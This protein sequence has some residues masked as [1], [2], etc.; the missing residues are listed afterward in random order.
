MPTSTASRDSVDVVI[1]G[2]GSAGCVLAERLSRHEKRSVLVLEQG[3]SEW[4][5]A[6]VLDL[7]RL[8]ISDGERY[9][10]HHR[11][12]S[13]LP[14]V[15]GRGLG[16]SSTVNGGYFM[17]FHRGDFDSWQRPWTPDVIDGAYAEVDEKMG[18][19]PFADADL[20][21]TA[22]AFEKYWGGTFP[23]RPLDDPW[24]LV[25][26]NRVRSN[27]MDGIRRTAADAYLRPHRDRPNLRVRTGATVERILL[28]EGNA[29]GVVCDGQDIRAREVILCAGTL[30]SAAVLLRS[31]V[32]GERMRV[33]EHREVLVGYRLREQLTPGPLLP[34]V[35]HTDDG[36]EIRC[37]RD[38]FARYIG[39]L[40]V[41]GP[42]VGVA[43]MTPGAS[44]E[45]YLDGG[46]VGVRLDQPDARVL[47]HL[48]RT[49][50]E[51]VEMLRSSSFGELVVADS[52][53]IDP[54]LRTSQH[55]WGSMPMG[56]RTDWLGGVRGVGH[57]RVVDGS[58]LPA[59]GRS[60]P[61]ATTMMVAAV[62][63]DVVAAD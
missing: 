31:G 45:V 37:Y 43:A 4:P 14:V 12:S 9:V 15:R 33:R 17:R 34:T 5:D 48:S 23:T 29:V 6:S 24:P 35:V 49:A 32:T 13:G 55:A 36:L 40:A 1:V 18:A 11:E 3:P 50:R 28:A 56:G 38:D 60:G 61:H 16:G 22:L 54:V 2:A 41:T 44:G 47:R 57:L 58:I 53:A 27:S 30:G 19:H 10:T 26:V 63:G 25:G 39:G 52:I 8:P 46:G 21:P 42:A 7:R 59:A 51:V 20:A 62:I